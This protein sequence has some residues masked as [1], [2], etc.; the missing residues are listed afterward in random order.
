MPNNKIPDAAR[1]APDL[2][3]GLL[4]AARLCADRIRDIIWKEQ[5]N[6]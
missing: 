2:V 6:D 1:I 5:A 3:P 4:E